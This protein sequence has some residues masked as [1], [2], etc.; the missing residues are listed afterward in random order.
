[1]H[2]VFNSLE[3]EPVLSTS[4]D[5]YRTRRR[6]PTLPD[7]IILQIFQLRA[8]EA[9]CHL[10]NPLYCVETICFFKNASLV[11]RRWYRLA[12]SFLPPVTVS[13]HAL[14]KVRPHKPIFMRLSRCK[15][16]I[17]DD[18][19][20][21]SAKPPYYG[22]PK[23]QLPACALAC[24]TN[25]TSLNIEL[26]FYSHPG[27][28]DFLQTIATQ[29]NHL[30]LYARGRAPPL[31]YLSM[32]LHRNSNLEELVLDGIRLIHNESHAAEPLFC[33]HVVLEDVEVLGDVDIA[34][35]F[36]NT[37]RISIYQ[38]KLPSTIDNSHFLS[39]SKP[40][41]QLIH[42][43]IECTSVYPLQGRLGI[44]QSP[45][46]RTLRIDI[47]KEC[48]ASYHQPAPP[49][50]APVLPGYDMLNL[51]TL[52][53]SVTPVGKWAFDMLTICQRLKD[54]RY[55]PRLASL[56]LLRIPSKTEE[57]GQYLEA[58]LDEKSTRCITE[59]LAGLQTRALAVR[60][61]ADLDSTIWQCAHKHLKDAVCYVRK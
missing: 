55:C 47:R 29:V 43:E 8:D 27:L 37:K 2:D 7:E 39:L 12:G 59:T 36:P 9:L 23:L 1:M 50:N 33:S 30:S 46:L 28:K 61:S 40:S 32:N 22:L 48:R 4:L 42:L 57:T 41:P 5:R 34:T 52:D 24:A 10:H 3:L 45:K 21:D 35:V 26:S 54:P 13:A 49:S 31:D 53:I 56:P 18:Y 51:A 14:F 38:R 60:S 11:C 16:L 19:G 58:Y 15:N 44:L 25:I 17:L 20:L 6:A